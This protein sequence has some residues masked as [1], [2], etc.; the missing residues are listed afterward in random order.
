MTSSTIPYLKGLRH[1]LNSV[2]SSK[3]TFYIY[4]PEMR[5]KDVTKI[6]ILSPTSSHR[7]HNVINMTVPKKIITGVNS[8]I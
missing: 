1:N 7:H 5:P 6:S 2:L 3:P 4:S 8:W